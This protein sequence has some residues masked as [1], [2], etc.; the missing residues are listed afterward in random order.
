[1]QQA[2]RSTVIQLWCCDMTIK[3]HYLSAEML[4]LNQELQY[5]PKLQ[6]YLANHAAEDFLERLAEIARYCNIELDGLYDQ[7]D[8][9][10]LAELCIPRLKKIRDKEADPRGVWNPAPFLETPIIKTG[11]KH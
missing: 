7:K 11:K 8:L 6:G 9:D 2:L 10:K 3:Y 4:A 1:M 5:H